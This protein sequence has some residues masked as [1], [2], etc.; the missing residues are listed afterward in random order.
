LKSLFIFSP[1]RKLL[2]IEEIGEARVRARRLVDLKESEKEEKMREKEAAVLLNYHLWLIFH[3]HLDIFF[4]GS[5]QKRR[6]V[7]SCSSLRQSIK[8]LAMGGG[9]REQRGYVENR[10][11]L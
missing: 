5:F 9:Q 4:A 3:H 6:I 2:K 11:G 1:L 8:Q 7:A 10:Y